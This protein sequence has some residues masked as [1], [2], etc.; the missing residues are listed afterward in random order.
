[1]DVDGISIKNREGSISNKTRK[2]TVFLYFIS[3]ASIIIVLLG[4]IFL[5]WGDKIPFVSKFANLSG[6]HVVY[7]NDDSIYFGRIKSFSD[8]TVSLYDAY[9]LK[10]AEITNGST[11]SSDF[12]VESM[13]KWYT[14]VPVKQ[15]DLSANNSDIV[16]MGKVN[17][18]IGVM[19]AINQKETEK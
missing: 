6:F 10:P 15:N 11:T 8:N 3:F 13:K 14:V 2:A 16:F 4:L 9:I 18:R 5:L 17:E 19:S 12:S 1:M 7:L